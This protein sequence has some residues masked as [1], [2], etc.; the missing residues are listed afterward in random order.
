VLNKF[1]PMFDS[2]VY[3]TPTIRVDTQVYPNLFT[4]SLTDR[5]MPTSYGNL[6]SLFSVAV[7]D[8]NF[9]VQYDPARNQLTFN[10]Q[11]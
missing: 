10:F 4:F 2:L 3:V 7:N 5:D 9:Y 8:T 1:D 6:S 11:G